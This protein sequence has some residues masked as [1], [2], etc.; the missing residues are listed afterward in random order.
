MNVFITGIYD[1]DIHIEIIL[2]EQN[3]S[4]LSK[5]IRDLKMKAGSEN[6]LNLEGT[7]SLTNRHALKKTLT[8]EKYTKVIR[9]MATICLLGLPVLFR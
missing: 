8:W 9:P 1:S 6:E 2:G 5:G 4:K 3:A 7:I